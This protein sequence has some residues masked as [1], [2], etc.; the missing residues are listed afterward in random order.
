MRT[1]KNSRCVFTFLFLRAATAAPSSTATTAEHH[2]EYVR[3]ISPAAAVLNSF[4]AILIIQLSL[5]FVGKNLVRL[6]DLLK[7]LRVATCIGRYI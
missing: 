4:L 7:R 5:V 1:A 3:R 6:R 2:V